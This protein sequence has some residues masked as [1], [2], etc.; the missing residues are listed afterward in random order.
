VLGANGVNANQPDG[1]I[2]SGVQLRDGRAGPAAKDSAE[3]S[4]RDNACS[5]RDPTDG[6]KV[7]VI[8]VAV[9]DENGV[10]AADR[11]RVD[12]A[13]AAQVQDARS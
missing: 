12:R 1:G 4:G 11:A 8:P 10:D 7:Q 3:P 2:A 9:R 13:T 5:L 6:R